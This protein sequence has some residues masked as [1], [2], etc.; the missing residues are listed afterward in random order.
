MLERAV[1][2][3]TSYAP[4]W[5]TLGRRSCVEDRLIRGGDAGKNYR[6]QRALERAVTIDPGYIPAAAGLVVSRADRGEL[7]EAHERAQD[8]VRRR[9]DSVDAHF[10]L[11][12]VLRFA[13]LWD[14]SA[15]H[16]ER[17]LL[18]DPQTQ[19]AGLRS[20][21][22]LFLLRGDYP[23]ALTYLNLDRGSAWWRA[24]SL[25]ML[26][27]QGK[28]QDALEIGSP[29]IPQ[30]ASYDLLL[31]CVQ[32]RS[33]PRLMGWPAPCDRRRIPRRITYPLLTS[34]TA[35]RPTRLARC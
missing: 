19:T 6:Y 11:S 17:A 5:L 9:P 12:Y 33:H 27:R 28:K 2:L 15:S 31:A 1:E 30:W 20:C 24:I 26:V 13:G 3:D 18:L 34:R 22:I 14:E 10:V 32:D 29:R 4:A 21:A 16:C 7:V 8:L 25:D 35:V 23:R